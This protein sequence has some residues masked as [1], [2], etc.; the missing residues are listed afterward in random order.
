MTQ[1]DRL[2][3]PRR[4]SRLPISVATAAVTAAIV[5]FGGSVA[6]VLEAARAVGADAAETSSWIAALCLGIAG[7]SLYLSWRHR[8]PIITAW[9]TPGAAVIGTSAVGIGMNQAV[10]A[11]LLAAVLVVV[12]MAFRPLGRLLEKLPTT[13]AAAMLAGILIR[14][15]LAV[16]G[17]AQGAPFFVLS[18]VA[19][20]FLAGLWTASLAVP[21]VLLAGIATAV[22]T[23]QMA[24]DCCQLAVTGLVP[25]LPDFQV[26]VLVGVALP[27]Y[28]VTMASQNLAGLAVLKADGYKA[29]AAASILPTGL[30]SVALAPF[31]AHGV[32][33]SAITAAICSG[34]SCHRDP[35]RRWLAGPL[36]ALCYVM[37]AAL[38]ET[39]VGLLL[40]LPAALIT[41]FTGLALFA[42]LKGALQVALAGDDR[43][44]ALLTFVIAASG[45]S[46]A[47]IGSALWAL[48]AGLL[49]YGVKRLR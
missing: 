8:M 28:L 33:L 38:T 7:T 34:P 39:F 31:G 17:A 42:P 18:L 6:L 29:P 14:F 15:C 40:A 1:E 27:L 24:A 21:I 4:V 19:V 44:A 35:A 22:V 48:I 5:G 23:G 10:G 13:I 25:A 47:G 36:Y 46:L 43:D 16:A 41:T 26:P 32:C 3:T 45:V 37:F 30:A 11:F 9:S 20:F 12:T 49:L 2:E